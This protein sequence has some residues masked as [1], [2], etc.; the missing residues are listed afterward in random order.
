MSTIEEKV[1][2]TVKNLNNIS[3]ES[4]VEAA[5]KIP[6]VKVNRNEY[7]S[8][9]FENEPVDI[10]RVIQDGPV[11]AMLPQAKLEEIADNQIRLRVTQSSAASF[12]AGM[13]GGL[14]LAATIPAD[15]L[16]F[17][18]MTLR[19]AQEIAYLYG[20][21]SFWGADGLVNTYAR[22]ELILYVGAMYDIPGAQAAARYLIS[23]NGHQ[24][25]DDE[26]N[27][28]VSY[29]GKEVCRKLTASTATTGIAKLFPVIGGIVSGGAT[30]IQLSP[31]GN[32]LMEVYSDAT[33]HYTD[34]KAEV[35]FSAISDVIERVANATNPCDDMFENVESEEAA[36]A[37]EETVEAEADV[38][39]KIR[40]LAKLKDEGIITEKEYNEK[41][42]ELLNQL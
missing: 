22:D 8:K 11:A 39:E 17:F 28:I 21:E 16:Q 33:F 25:E 29:I 34:I 15:T 32:R 38:F 14:A 12:I 26:W 42:K 13:P 23:D 35:D 9:I 4:V 6:G 40:K 27:A 10:L 1:N 7:L 3:F 18:G 31:M 37:K 19:M 41:K 36:P 5:V 20:A 2:E 24:I 30:F